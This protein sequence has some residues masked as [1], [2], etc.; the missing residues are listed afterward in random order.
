M[1]NT[2][3]F[4]P[5]LAIRNQS[6][7]VGFLGHLRVD[8]VVEDPRESK[9]D[10][11]NQLIQVVIRLQPQG[12]CGLVCLY[13]NLWRKEHALVKQNDG[14][15]KWE[16]NLAT[17]AKTLE[18]CKRFSYLIIRVGVHCPNLQEVER[19]FHLRLKWASCYISHAK[20]DY[21]SALRRSRQVVCNCLPYLGWYLGGHEVQPPCCQNLRDKREDDSSINKV[22]D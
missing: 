18:P 17:K 11:A 3:L 8:G 7:P 13:D 14:E 15:N 22:Q 20:P 16:E 9:V 2:M 10:V 6:K 1:W 12:I 19:L 5:S 21:C 4:S